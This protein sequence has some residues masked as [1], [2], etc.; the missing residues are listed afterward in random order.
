MTSNDDLD[1]IENIN[2]ESLHDDEAEENNNLENDGE[3]NEENEQ[4]QEHNQENEQD[5][6][7]ENENN[8][9]NQNE[10]EQDNENENDNEQQDEENNENNDHNENEEN[11]HH[12][13]H[14]NENQDDEVILD[15]ENNNLNDYKP[16]DKDSKLDINDYHEL[17]QWVD[18]FKF[19]KTKKNLTRDFSDG[20]NFTE[21]IIKYTG[22]QVIESH[23]VVHTLHKN[24][25]RENWKVIQKKLHNK[26][27]IQI[28]N[29]QIEDIIDLKP[30]AIEGLLQTVHD[31]FTNEKV[32]VMKELKKETKKIKNYMKCINS[33]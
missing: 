30:Y 22:N 6:E 28:T 7:Q 12:N 1:N 18:T 26:T 5:Q 31:L 32:N 2:Q 23:N 20:V 33:K 29:Q 25:K 19:N 15:P 13:E 16:K 8:E 9:E 24:Q 10:N 21:I 11:E 4:D 3:N 17:Y 14:E 27:I